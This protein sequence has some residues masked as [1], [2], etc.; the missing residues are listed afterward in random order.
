MSNVWA[1][2]RID[3]Q[4]P[5]VTVQIHSASP[6]WWRVTCASHFVDTCIY[7]IIGVSL[8]DKH[9]VEHTMDTLALRI[10]PYGLLTIEVYN[11]QSELPETSIELMAR[12][13]GDI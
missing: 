12:N 1:P 4:F 6:C 9:V 3:L 5:K 7:I 10:V 13:D 11:L 2:I 8:W